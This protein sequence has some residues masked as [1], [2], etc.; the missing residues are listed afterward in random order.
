[1]FLLFQMNEREENKY[2]RIDQA[3]LLLLLILLLQYL[4]KLI[5]E[6]VDKKSDEPLIISKN[7]YFSSCNIYCNISFFVLFE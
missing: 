1:M 6:L 2:M 7:I 4:L 3:L 5:I